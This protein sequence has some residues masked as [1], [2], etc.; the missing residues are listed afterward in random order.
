MS[1]DALVPVVSRLATWL[2]TMRAP[3][4]YSGPVAH[5]WQQCLQYTG[6][7]IDWRY[8]GIITGYLHLYR[9]TRN[10]HWLAQ[11]CRAADDVVQ[12][13]LP[14]TRLPNSSF[15][16]NPYPG[17]TPHEAACMLALL[18]LA[19]ILHQQGDL[20]WQTYL[21]VA[22]R[23]LWQ[24][25]IARLWD[26]RARAFR[27]APDVPSF[28]PNKAATLVQA[29]LMLAHLTHDEHLITHYA[30]PTLDVVLAHQVQGDLLD[31]AIYQNSFGQRR[32]PKFFPY[33]IARCI[34]ALLAG[35]E[36]SSEPRYLAAAQRALNFILRWR[37]PDGSLPQ[38]I[39]T[40][41]RVSRYPCWI[42]AT[43]D[44]ITAMHLL[45]PHGSPA[46]P[47]P[48]LHWLLQGQLPSGGFRTAHGFAEHITQ[49][50]PADLPE[51]RDLLPVC[52]WNDKAFACLS[53]LLEPAAAQHVTDTEPLPVCE[54]ACQFRR[55]PMVYH[56]DSQQI[57]LRQGQQ[58]HYQWQKGA[59][60]PSV[61]TPLM[62]L[63]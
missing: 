14:D 8:E 50:T 30:L 39:Y 46:D 38:V 26:E 41:G 37:T 2:T 20:R 61:C 54:L 7:G 15:E 44:I 36:V 4:G 58:I 25:Q 53:G 43:G 55:Q 45:Q 22:G 32:V 28:V 3:D 52:G 33:Y 47:T 23:N 24:H 13:Q 1:S 18:R 49:R 35:Y 19:T 57:V 56:E 16:Q 62:Y 59:A 48:T 10:P 17:G 34:P 63:K 5:W 42:A 40:S 11:A 60:W 27:D 51:F 29:L 12:A 21:A 6:A 9:Y 31:G